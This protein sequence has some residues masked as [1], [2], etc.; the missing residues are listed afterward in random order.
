MWSQSEERQGVEQRAIDDTINVISWG[1]Q[2]DKKDYKVS[3]EH[4]HPGDNGTRDTT[5]ISNK[6]HCSQGSAARRWNTLLRLEV[7]RCP[8]NISEAVDWRNH[9]RLLCPYLHLKENRKQ[10]SL[11]H[12]ALWDPFTRRDGMA[13]VETVKKMNQTKN[14]GLGSQTFVLI[15]TPLTQED[16]LSAFKT[17]L[18]TRWLQPPPLRKGSERSDAEQ[19]G[20]V[21]P[22]GA[23]AETRGNHHGEKEQSK[24][25]SAGSGPRKKREPGGSIC[26]N[27]WAV[28]VAT[29]EAAT[30]QRFL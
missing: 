20:Q 9:H 17:C 3:V 14:N 4:Q 24:A 19:S 7:F 5:A 6:P 23:A 28:V 13:W 30:M 12:K 22:T 29:P 1:N 16:S 2:H 11:P 8:F 15:R 25:P 27:C 26:T 10:H 21:V 18:T